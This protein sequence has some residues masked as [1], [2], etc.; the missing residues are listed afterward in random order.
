MDPS[1]E[2]YDPAL[3]GAH[4]SGPVAA[5]TVDVVPTLQRLQV[6]DPDCAYEPA[7]HDWH[8]ELDGL[9]WPVE[10]LPDEHWRH[11]AVEVACIPV[12]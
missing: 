11:S 1:A 7:T 8:V 10:N 2:A 3:H 6:V 12:K 5:D 9:P 4:T